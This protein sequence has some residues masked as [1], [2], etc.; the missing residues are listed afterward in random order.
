MD[1]KAELPVI[2]AIV[3]MVIIVI[4]VVIII[5]IVI[6]AIISFKSCFNRINYKEYLFIFLKF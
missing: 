4:M 1:F 2:V 6:F 5:N 3:I